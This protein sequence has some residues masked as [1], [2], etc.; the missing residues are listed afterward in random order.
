MNP[1][2]FARENAVIKVDVATTNAFAALE[3]Y[4]F[5]LDGSN[6]AIPIAAVTDVPRGLC[7]LNREDGTEISAAIPGGGGLAPVRVKLGANVTDLRKDLQ[8]R[9]DGSAGPDAGTGARVLVARPLETG[10]T[11][12]LIEAVLI[13]PVSYAT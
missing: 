4:F 1:R 9:A 3:G 10:N 8:L 13:Y 7:L 11:D 2:L 5:K 6:K 12:E